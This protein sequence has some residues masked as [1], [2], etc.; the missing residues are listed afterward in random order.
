MDH[1]RTTDR[2]ALCGS[3]PGPR[4]CVRHP[5][6]WVLSGRQVNP[7]SML[8][9]RRCRR[10]FSQHET[11]I[12]ISGA[13]GR[14]PVAR[15]R[16]LTPATSEST[17]VSCRCGERTALAPTQRVHRPTDKQAA[18]PFAT[19]PSSRHARPSAMRTERGSSSTMRPDSSVARARISSR[20][21]LTCAMDEISTRNSGR[22]SA[23]W[24]Q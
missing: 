7:S 3:H 4:T 1:V 16:P 13:I 9:S 5:H 11:D 18:L 24:M 10:S 17:Q 6:R 12:P 19:E 23:A 15:D 14:R 21:A 20:Y 8:P 2:T 22:T